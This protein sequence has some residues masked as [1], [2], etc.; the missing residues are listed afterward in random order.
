M[1]TARILKASALAAIIIALAQPRLPVYRSKVSVAMLADVSASIPAEGLAVESALANE[2]ENARGRNSMRVIPFARNTRD[3]SPDEH[4]KGKWRLRHTA[5][6]GGRATDLEAA[7]R[8]GAATLPPATIRRLLLVSDGNE[9]LGSVERAIWQARQLGIP[10]DTAPLAGRPKQGLAVES[11]G[12]PGQVFSGERFPIEV[13]LESP[14]RTSAAVELSAEGK[15]I[16]AS[17]VTLQQ[18]ANRVRLQ[19]SVNAAGAIALAGVITAP[20]LGE[21][22]FDAALTLR[23]PRALYV[24]RD[25]AE[26]ERQLLKSL[27][28]NQFEIARAPEGVP[29]TLDDYQLVVI[30]NWDIHSIPV[31]RQA[32]LEQ[33]VER[34]GGLLW[35]GGERN[36][37]LDKGAEEPLQRALPAT[38]VPPRNPEGAA[39][40]LIIDKSSSMEGQKMELAKLAAVGVVQNLRPI[41]LV[42]V[43]VFDSSFEWAVP[44]RPAADRDGI[45]RLISGIEADGG[46]QIAPALVEAYRKVLPLQAAYKHIVLLTDGISEEGDSLELARRARSARVTIST[47]GLGQDVNRSYLEKIAKL[48]EGRS[49]MLDEPAGLEQ[50][51]LRDVEEHSVSTAVEKAMKP[52]V[53]QRA[54]VL[55]GVGIES[56]PPL[57]GYVRYRSRPAADTIL[58]AGVPSQPGDPLLVRW[59]YGLGR[60]AIFTSD[61]KP[62]WAADWVTWPG[63]DR[64]WANVARDL[65]PR[66]QP[67]ETSAEYDRASNELVVDYRMGAAEAASAPDIYVFGPN[68]FKAPLR[69][70]KVAE[71]H[72]RGRVAIG[73]NQGLF[74]VR[75]VAESRAFPEIGF[76]RQEDEMLEYG[77]NDQLLH[78][79]AEATGGR[80]NPPLNN[81][82]DSTGRAIPDAIRKERGRLVD[83]IADSSAHIHG[84]KFALYGDPLLDR[85]IDPL[86][87]GYLEKLGRRG[88]VHADD[89]E[90]GPEQPIDVLGVFLQH[91]LRR[92]EHL[93]GLT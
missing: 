15:P 47:V 75:P 44:I 19:A 34:G 52:K 18:G 25:P 20:D 3:A 82:F 53:V 33:F 69:L 58:E 93:G 32:A 48:A 89:Q 8:D 21:A 72:Y 30:N 73:R 7:I 71:G 9:N 57:R 77:A 45:A 28:A 10:V 41:D 4:P 22:R 90:T 63:F 29:E 27:E 39:V 54:G 38:L 55:E 43:L 37:Y 76:Y 66:A 70:D 74:R 84:K 51:L 23:R 62:R 67:M 68:D 1:T 56:A 64:L 11:V 49:Y 36:V 35:I 85:S 16:G 50:I 59:Q 2:L 26:S 91:F 81:I 31:P 42:G 92:I 83:A 60:A 46:T 87:D 14:R 5:G 17:Q 6:D 79:V 40:A 24:S 13:T 80:Y 78:Q 12:L 86:P 61:A 65:L 88:V